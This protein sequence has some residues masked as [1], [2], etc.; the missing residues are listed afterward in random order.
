MKPEQAN[1]IAAWQEQARKEGWKHPEVLVSALE[2]DPNLTKYVGYCR[3]CQKAMADLVAVLED[4]DD[5]DPKLEGARD[6]QIRPDYEW[7]MCS[8]CEEEDFSESVEDH[9]LW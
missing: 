8:E 1:A 2:K 9:K 3:K 7:A 4:V 5:D 6:G